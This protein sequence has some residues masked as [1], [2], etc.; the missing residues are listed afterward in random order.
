MGSKLTDLADLKPSAD[1][2]LNSFLIGISDELLESDLEKLKFLCRGKYGIGKARLE[3]VK[4][5]L[6]LFEILREKELLNENNIIT[7]QSMLWMLPRKDLQ[8]RFVEFADSLDSSIHFV[9]P[10]ETPENGFKYLK[11]HI[12]GKNLNNYGRTELERL[13]SMVAELLLVPKEFIIIS[14]IEPSNSLV[15][16]IMVPEEFASRVLFSD[17]HKLAMLNEVSVSHVG[18]D[19]DVVWVQED[20]HTHLLTEDNMGEEARSLMLRQNQMEREL[21]QAHSKI[22]TLTTQIDDMKKN[23]RSQCMLYF[24]AVLIQQM[25]DVYINIMKAS[26]FMKECALDP[27]DSLQ[28]LCV[29]RRFRYQLEKVRKLGYDENIVYDLLD[30]QALVFQWQK[31]EKS[32]ITIVD[33]ANTIRELE[34]KLAMVSW[35]RDKLAYYHGIGIQD[36]V[37]SKRDEYCFSALRENIGIPFM[38]EQRTEMEIPEECIEYVFK[39]L[40]K[41]ISKDDLKILLEKINVTGKPKRYA[42]LSGYQYLKT[43]HD[44]QRMHGKGIE[45]RSFVQYYLADPLQRTDFLEKLRIY[46]NEFISNSQTTT[47]GRRKAERRK[48]QTY[49]IRKGS[50]NKKS[51]MPRSQNRV[52]NDAEEKQSYGEIKEMLSELKEMLKTQVSK[53]AFQTNKNAVF[54]GY[55][56]LFDPSKRIPMES[57]S[58]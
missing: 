43:A 56:A 36:K 40:D 26:K 32:D 16:T 12:R 8:K 57:K 18:L 35:E 24:L 34:R 45:L 3:K 1:Y 5:A 28:K 6:D 9:V 33:L 39:R 7:L 48:P 27:V 46:V 54:N 20:A 29:L 23:D 19:E 17:P 4:S 52:V 11:F 30:A 50:G 44:I 51:A 31:H 49:V 14:G 13:R 58:F 47:G 37:M 55:R 10:K 25:H 22:A 42:A 41:D 38:I 53:N 15:I 2:A 21:E